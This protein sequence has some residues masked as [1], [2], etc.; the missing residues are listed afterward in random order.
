MW[1]TKTKP[2]RL[3]QENTYR[4]RVNKWLKAGHSGSVL[5]YFDCLMF[6]EEV[7]LVHGQLDVGR[8][9]ADELV[10]GHEEEEE[11]MLQHYPAQQP[12]RVHHRLSLLL[13]T[14]TQLQG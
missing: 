8:H 12:G 4:G 2:F 7:R 3:Y 6:E 1:V 5:L 13:L 11:E 14:T 10:N 9:V